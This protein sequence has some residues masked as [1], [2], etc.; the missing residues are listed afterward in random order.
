[1]PLILLLIS[2]VLTLAVPQVLAQGIVDATGHYGGDIGTVAAGTNR[3]IS[4]DLAR[5][6]INNY[7]QGIS[8]LNIPLLV[9][10][11]KQAYD[12]DQADKQA[13]EFGKAAIKAL[14]DTGTQS[15][16]VD[17]A[18]YG[19]D[20]KEINDYANNSN[21]YIAAIRN[22]VKRYGVGLS[23]D[24]S[25]VTTPIGNFSTQGD[26]GGTIIAQLNKFGLSTNG[27]REALASADGERDKIAKNASADAEG[28]LAAIKGGATVAPG[29]AAAPAAAKE[30][31]TPTTAEGARSLASNPSF[32]LTPGS[33]SDS[34]S[35]KQQQ[36]E[37][38]NQRDAL[39]RRMGLNVK[40]A[41]NGPIGSRE[42]D[43]F[44]MVHTHYQ[45]LRQQDVFMET[46]TL[47]SQ[48]D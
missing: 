39:A 28:R 35:F 44:N 8:T 15:G 24:G 6:A 13:K 29:A 16:H 41:A 46:E 12:S 43:L 47:F 33:E 9:K 38:L 17:M 31:D 21:K 4:E 45:Q 10:A 14:Q 5:S 34:S 2:V 22:E 3:R 25:Q 19:A 1:M 11:G 30:G 40:P 48:A 23:D 20:I 27:V 18:K 7:K 32:T 37:F 42:Q 36:T 26:I